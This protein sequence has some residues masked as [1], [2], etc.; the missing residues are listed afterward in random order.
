M[1]E[2]GSTSDTVSAN[3]FYLSNYYVICIA[4]VGSYLCFDLKLFFRC[5]S[6]IS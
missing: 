3:I 6:F 2:N 4:S 5:F 1:I